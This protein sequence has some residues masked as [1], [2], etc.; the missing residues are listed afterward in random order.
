MKILW[1]S[2]KD[3]KHPLAGGAEVVNEELAKRL[4]QDGHEVVFLTGGFAGGAKKETIDGYRIIRLG[5]RFS[6]YWEAYKYYKKN[7]VGW[8]DLVIDEV[9]T[10]PFFAK[11]YLKTNNILF[12]HQLCREI[13]FYQMIFPLNVIGYL[14]EPIYL[15]L[16]NDRKVITVSESTKKDLMR[17]GFKEKNIFVISEGIEMEPAEEL[18]N[19]KIIKCEVPTM[20]SLGALRS[21]KRTDQIVKAFEIAK[22]SLPDL[23]LLVSGDASD[24]FGK[25]VLKLIEK[26]PYK[27][28]IGYLGKISNDDKVEIMRRAHV[29]CVTSVKEGWGLIVTEANSQGTPAIVYD[30]DGLRDSVRHGQT[31]LVC[32]KNTPQDFARNVVSLLSDP[33]RYEK[34]RLTGW[35]WSKEITF[36]KSYQDFT[37]KL[38]I[39]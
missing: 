32:A 18:E 2:W 22:K 21:M 26:S 38:K 6:V 7:L 9:N 4:A 1:M 5:N 15:W 19:H 27:E 24:S 16:L 33:E 20:L 11:F 37:T 35:Q 31:G 39:N 23:R 14:L 25:K 10:I 12:I 28:S 30:V 3:K 8:S 13:W 36:E 29:I 34:M 17:F